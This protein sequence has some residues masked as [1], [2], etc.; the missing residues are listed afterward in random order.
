MTLSD[1]KTSNDSECH[2]ASLLGIWHPKRMQTEASVHCSCG[3]RVVLNVM[4]SFYLSGP[5]GT[6]L[7][8]TGVLLNI[9]LAIR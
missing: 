1:S 7:L 8:H 6:L 4:I 5:Q 3:R 9:T 2:M